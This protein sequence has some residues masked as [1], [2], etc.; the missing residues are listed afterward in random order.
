MENSL[1]ILGMMIVA[2]L[3]A[4]FTTLTLWR[5]VAYIQAYKFDRD[6][7]T[8]LLGLIPLRLLIGLYAGMALF[9]AGFSILI[10]TFI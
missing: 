4:G 2:F 6:K 7:Y 9:I 10:F 3:S 8:P 1:F 5:M